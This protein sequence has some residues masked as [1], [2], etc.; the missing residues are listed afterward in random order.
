MSTS[1]DIQSVRTYHYPPTGGNNDRTWVKWLIQNQISVMIGITLANY[2]QELDMLSLDYN[3]PLL[4]P[5]FDQLTIAISI[6]N[7]EDASQI[8]N[9]QAGIAYAKSLILTGNLPVSKLT[10]VLKDDGN[11]LLNTYPPES[12]VF[13]PAFATLQT[14]LDIICFNMYD[15]YFAPANVPVETKLSWTSN[16][17]SNLS[18]TLNGFGAV[19][20]AMR[21]SG[22]V[23]LFWNTEVGWQAPASSPTNPG[24]SIAYLK[25]FYTNYLAFD[26]LSLFTPQDGSVAVLGPDKIFYFTVRDVPAMSET[27]GLY[28]SSSVLTPK[29][30]A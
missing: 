12:A 24:N 8:A 18:V 29:F 16:G 30:T 23:Q 22:Y 15:A 2:T 6:G 27:F 4:K 14:S 5:L 9:M 1:S 20:T 28:T 7:E 21:K 3:D 17:T 25:E 19:R 11:W 10:S 26:M 13:T